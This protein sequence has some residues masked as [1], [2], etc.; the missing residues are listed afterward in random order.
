MAGT[1]ASGLSRPT[2]PDTDMAATG[3]PL[4][5]KIGAATQLRPSDASSQSNDT[6]AVRVEAAHF[7]ELDPEPVAARRRAFDAPPRLE[8]GQDPVGGR[9]RQARPHGE[10]GQAEVGLLGPERVEHRQQLPGR[11]RGVQALAGSGIPSRGTSR[12]HP[13]PLRPKLSSAWVET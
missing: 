4:W 8:R 6:P 1:S 5:L 12:W 13:L 7:E 2:G 10:L 9:L 11:G 3:W